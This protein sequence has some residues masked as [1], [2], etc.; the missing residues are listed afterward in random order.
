MTDLHFSLGEK[1][2]ADFPGGYAF[3]FRNG[4]LY[5]RTPPSRAH[6]VRAK[7]VGAGPPDSAGPGR[8][9]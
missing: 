3:G 1:T 5:R 9:R 4:R 2:N 7:L 8:T 6:L